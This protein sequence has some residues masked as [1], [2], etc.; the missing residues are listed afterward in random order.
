VK[1]K[2][3]WLMLSWLIVAAL[4]LASCGEVV[5]G[6]QEEEEEE[7]EPV[8][9]EPQYGGTLIVIGANYE[10]PSPA[11][12]DVQ[13]GSLYWL[14]NIQE[15][16]VAG[17]VETYGPKPRGN[18]EWEF[19]ALMYQ[20]DQYLTGTFLEDWEISNDKMVWHVRPGVMWAPT[21][22]QMERGVMDE[23]R[24]VTAS[25]IVYDIIEFLTSPWKGRFEGFIDLSDPASV[26]YA[27]DRYT[28]VVEFE[29]YNPMIPYY[30]MYEDR[31]L[32]APPETVEAGADKWSNQIG[33]GPFMFE[34]YVV[35]S[36]MSFTR[37][38]NYWGKT[39]INGE[40]YQLPFVDRVI[41][42]IIPDLTTEMAALQT[43]KL[44]IQR[45]VLPE[46][47]GVL[48]SQA[49]EMGKKAYAS[50]YST[51]I[52]LRCDEPPFDNVKVRRACA[53]GTDLMKFKRLL[54]FE[55]TPLF[56]YPVPPGD[57]SY[58]PLEEMP[59]DIQVLFEYNPDLA[60]QMLAEAGYEEGF[61][62]T[63]TFP[64]ETVQWGDMAA[65]LKD[66]WAKI[67]IEVE[68][69]PQPQVI[70]KDMG[71]P[72]PEVQYHGVY[73][74]EGGNANP[75]GAID[76][77]MRKTGLFNRS[78]YRNEN[79]DEI[80]SKLDVEL[81]PEKRTEMIHEILLDSIPDVDQIQLVYHQD[82][83]YWWPWVKNYYGEYSLQDDGSFAALFKF[84]WID[85][86]L[87]A[88]MGYK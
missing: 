7:E 81:D 23:P 71:F 11:F 61:K 34:E 14:E 37:N 42:P 59:A 4:V 68:L 20:P 24:E 79:L 80:M 74:D 9:G 78:M 88:E 28:L 26:V 64:S 53:I 40:E 66:Q 47:W 73:S 41:R 48:D 18:G 56:F 25:D 1:K 87:K 82:R 44:D 75:T 22:D 83:A 50:G 65:M 63:F 36:H 86:T 8:A 10:P 39:T 51:R 69:N 6:E 85:Q 54:E 52:Y 43:G 29:A 67:G 38:P 84:I 12:T 15:R 17:D 60:K 76:T 62:T 31:A 27:T 49:P 19:C 58:I 13:Y 21:E 77:Y 33:T 35:G 45:K 30:I 46:Y 3:V 57:P 55:E 2:F 70:Y 16:P 5:P 72:I 32:Y